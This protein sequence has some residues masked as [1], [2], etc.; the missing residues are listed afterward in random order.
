[1]FEELCDYLHY[2]MLFNEYITFV[3]RNTDFFIILFFPRGDLA[4]SELYRIDEFMCICYWKALI[5]QVGF[6][7]RKEIGFCRKAGVPVLGPGAVFPFTIQ[8]LN[9]MLNNRPVVWISD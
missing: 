8:I 4:T 3:R 5:V 7:R 1:M 6:S 2:W 9:T